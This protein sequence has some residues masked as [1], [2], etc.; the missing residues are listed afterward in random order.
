MR[1]VVRFDLTFVWSLFQ[2]RDA[3][4]NQG[5]GN[6][7]HERGTVSGQIADQYGGP[8]TEGAEQVKDR[9]EPRCPRPRLASR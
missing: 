8:S 4:E 1:A 9:T 6:K 3:N 5:Q 2:E 7:A